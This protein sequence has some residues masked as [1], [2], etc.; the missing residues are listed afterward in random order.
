[1]KVSLLTM[2]AKLLL[3][4]FLIFAAASA[5]AAHLQR[6][7]H[8]S[9][10]PGKEQ[11][12][13]SFDSAVQPKVFTLDGN[14]PRIVFDFPAS[15]S[16]TR[17]I[18][19]RSNLVK[20]VRVGMHRDGDRKTRVVLD[21][22]SLKD[23]KVNYDIQGNKLIINLNGRERALAQE[24]PV[25]PKPQ[26]QVQAQ[27]QPQPKKIRKKEK[28]RLESD[29]EGMAETP[30]PVRERRRP[31][32]NKTVESRTTDL[33]TTETTRPTAAT[34]RARGAATTAA[35]A[36]TAGVAATAATGSSPAETGLATASS[37]GKP[38][39][40][41]PASAK[42]D[43]PYL[44][45]IQFDPD[46]PRG[47]LVQFK[48]NG[49]YPPELRSV[50]EG[51][52]QVI[53]EFKNLEVAPSL[54]GPLRIRGKLVQAVRLDKGEGGKVRVFVELTPDKHYDLQ[55]VFFK[56]ENFFVLMVNASSDK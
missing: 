27:P 17:G 23:L 9:A 56:E 18:A 8:Q 10:G 53:C 47:E 20:A 32:R 38:A 6:V 24:A 25:R 4:F 48:L 1:M 54:E 21:V 39:R 42:A 50:E 40:Q 35:A 12:V 28:S 7:Q 5:Q 33:G 16:S 2:F 19:P 55:Q 22:S 45:A 30:E 46:S 15:T 14:Q 52:P 37:S 44:S 41:I 43:T 29:T 36:A 26:P 34:A 11:V 51:K 13:V 3:P 31:D 49:F